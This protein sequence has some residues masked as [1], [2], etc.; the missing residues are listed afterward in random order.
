VLHRNQVTEFLL[1]K[2]NLGVCKQLLRKFDNRSVGSTDMTAR[3]AL[4]PQSGNDVNN[5]IDLIR[6]HRVEIDEVLT[7][8]LGQFDIGG[9]V[10]ICSKAPSVLFVDPS[11]LLFCIGLLRE[12]SLTGNFRDVVWLQV[13][14]QGKAIHQAGK[15]DA[16]VVQSTNQLVELFLRCDHHPELA[17]TDPAKRLHDSLQI[18]HL[19]H[20]P[21]HELTDF[22]DD[23]HEVAVLT[24]PC[25]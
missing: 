18:E 21:G 16:R 3:A 20:G 5:K 14:L 17:Q 2:A 22:V 24:A 7:S 1:A 23:E 12:Y 11:E 15:L 8:H 25:S 13:D 4:R 10:C 19:I 9:K 6:Q